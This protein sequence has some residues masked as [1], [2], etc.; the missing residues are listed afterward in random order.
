MWPPIIDFQT[1]SQHFSLNLTAQ[2]LVDFPW[3]L[4]KEVLAG[5]VELSC[6]LAWVG[7]CISK[8]VFSSQEIKSKS[9]HTAIKSFP[10]ISISNP[11]SHLH[12]E[13]P[14][15]RVHHTCHTA[16]I[17][18]HQARLTLLRGAHEVYVMN[19]VWT[20][21]KAPGDVNPSSPTSFSTHFQD[22][23]QTL[24]G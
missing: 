13:I 24:F 12:P 17:V 14:F 15:P 7:H 1:S 21:Q 18:V 3:N 23:T 20:C 11:L 10:S 16:G 22:L 6:L 8:L 4:S 5:Q 19:Q 2:L 9:Y